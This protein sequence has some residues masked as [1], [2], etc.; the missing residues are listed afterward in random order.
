MYA[1]GTV[2]STSASMTD[3]FSKF[4]LPQRLSP[5]LV[6]CLQ[7]ILLDSSSD[8]SACMLA[9]ELVFSSSSLQ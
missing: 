2:E 9:S 3:E 5:N 4:F 7:I 6:N 1:D 8:E